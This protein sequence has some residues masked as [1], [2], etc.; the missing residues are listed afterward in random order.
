MLAL[1]RLAVAGAGL[2]ALTAAAATLQLALQPE[3]AFSEFGP[4]Y[5]M[6]LTDV[7]HTL[8]E[9]VVTDAAP[10]PAH[11]RCGA[12]GGGITQGRIQI[13]AI[14]EPGFASGTPPLQCE[15]V[16]VVDVGQ[17]APGDYPMVATVVQPDG[18][19][20]ILNSTL[21]IVARGNKCNSDPTANTLSVALATKTMTEFQSALAN[22]S[23]YRA[24]L[25]PIAFVRASS[26]YDPIPGAVV[27]FPPLDDPL[28]VMDRLQGTGEFTRIDRSDYVCFSAP[29]PDAVGTAI[30]YYSG[31]LDHYFFT[32]D[33]NEK[34]AL[35]SGLVAG[36]WV[37]TGKSFLVTLFPGCRTLIEG[38]KHPV[39]RFVGEA[40]IGPDSHFFTVSQDECG[41]VRDRVDWHW[42]FEGA[43]FYASEPIAGACPAGFGKYGQALYRAYNNG[44]GGDPNH[45]YSTD[46]AVIQAM[47]DQ[48]WID[49]GLAMCVVGP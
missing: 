31:T 32:A 43:P 20:T 18:S 48:G 47:V 23:A 15:A 4:P 13:S 30:E 28:R 22:D 27:A 25:G 39:Y 40:N 36:G 38:G 8:V 17:L 16:A 29:P 35:D 34:T 24:A 41:V 26:I 1:V 33:A 2:V 19:V 12:T 42:M 3:S 14:I 45:R 7:G 46:P 11:F 10:P 5:V 9:I 21:S 6:T 49:E 44:K 37:R